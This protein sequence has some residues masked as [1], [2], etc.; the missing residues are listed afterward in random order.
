[1]YDGV[2]D[3]HQNSVVDEDG[4]IFSVQNQPPTPQV[5]AN[6]ESST[7]SHGTS[8][9]PSQDYL[10]ISLTSASI[11]PASHTETAFLERARS[12][13]S[14][15]HSTPV[16]T[17]PE[18]STSYFCSVV[19]CQ[20][21]EFHSL[22]ALNIHEAEAHRHRCE[23]CPNVGFP[24]I[25]DLNSRHRGP[26]HG[27]GTG[28]YTCGRCGRL[29]FRQDNHTRHIGRKQP[30]RPGP[31]AKPYTCGRC[32]HATCD[33]QQHLE[34]LGDRKACETNSQG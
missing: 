7:E 28:Q 31:R 12:F 33:K 16:T 6:Q 23:Q 9:F 8:N 24:S 17:P 18:T 13:A 26:V 19:P 2:L 21:K 15:V 32:N 27:M 4:G 1:M 14:A 29:D 34:H 20:Q 10:H 3:D 11:S 22:D 25:R 30:C 5:E